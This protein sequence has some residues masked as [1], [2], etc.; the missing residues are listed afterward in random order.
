MGKKIEEKYPDVVLNAFPDKILN[1][2][3]A[4]SHLMNATDLDESVIRNCLSE[5]IDRKKLIPS[6]DTRGNLFLSKMRKL[7]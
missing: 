5:L 6:K 1:V 3:E 2:D 4:I 7:Y